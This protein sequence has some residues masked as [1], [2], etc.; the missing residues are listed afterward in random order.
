MKQQEEAVFKLGESKKSLVL[1]QSHCGASAF[2]VHIQRLFCNLIPG[3]QPIATKSPDL[4]TMTDSLSIT[5]CMHPG[6][7]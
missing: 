7:N 5:R 1:A 4:T 2:W 3:C 6:T